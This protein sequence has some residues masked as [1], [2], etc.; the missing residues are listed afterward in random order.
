MNAPSLCVIVPA[1]NEAALIG[2][3]LSRIRVVL[4]DAAVIVSD[5]GSTD[6]TVGIAV[7]AGAEVIAAPRGRGSQCRAGAM[8]ATSDWLLF[9]HADTL[10]PL[11]AGVVFREFASKPAVQIGTFR[12]RFADGS[13]FLNALAWAASRGDCVFTRFGDQGILI[14]RS[15]YEELGGFPPWPLFEDVTLLQKAR[16]RSRVHWLSACVTTSA[17]RFNAQGL[18]RQRLL[19]AE[20]MLRYL[21]GASLFELAAHYRVHSAQP[22]PDLAR[23]RKMVTPINGDGA[24]L[25]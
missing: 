3:T 19:N 16:K 1:L 12:V 22:P 8:Q 11:E 18:L 4:P 7:R 9:F 2:Q 6:D 5:G 17:R 23:R 21:A 15:F 14:R 25:T 20:L 24:E 13:K 10:L